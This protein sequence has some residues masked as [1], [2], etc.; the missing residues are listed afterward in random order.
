MTEVKYPRLKVFAV[1]VLCPLVP[2]FVA[3][4]VNFVL[5]LAH[6]TSNPRLLGEVRGGELLLMPVLAP[7][8]TLLL[9]FLPFFG[10]ALGVALMKV[11]RSAFSC[12][13][14]SLI[15]GSLAMAWA[16]L[17]IREVVNDIATA[18]YSDY[19]LGL[20]LIFLAAAMTCWLTARLFLPQ[21]D[22]GPVVAK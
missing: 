11:R 22:P 2:G 17:F 4:L 9:F 19:L 14:L 8:V 21:Q 10:L 18:R 15:G 5:L 7:L 13:A 12:I 3:G 1:F 16:L 20:L 6:L